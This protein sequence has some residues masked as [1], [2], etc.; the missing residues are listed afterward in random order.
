MSELNEDPGNSYYRIEMPEYRIGSGFKSENC[1]EAFLIWME[2]DG[3]WII[4]HSVNHT[5]FLEI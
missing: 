5:T 4:Q 2:L 3:H 1:S